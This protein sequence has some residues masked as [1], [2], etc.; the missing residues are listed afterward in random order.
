MT[1]DRGELKQI[2]QSMGYTISPDA[3]GKEEKADEFGQEKDG[4]VEVSFGQA[5][6]LV[7]A[8]APATMRVHC[9]AIDSSI[10]QKYLI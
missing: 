5:R 3:L 7:V 6:W 9:L 10:I 1:G 8:A 4:R 2:E